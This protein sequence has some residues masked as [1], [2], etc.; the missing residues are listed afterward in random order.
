MATK[1]KPQSKAKAAAIK[2]RNKGAEGPKKPNFVRRAEI[3]PL[4]RGRRG[5]VTPKTTTSL[6]MA[7][8]QKTIADVLTGL[9]FQDN[10][11]NAN[12]QW[13]RAANRTL[14][15]AKAQEGAK[16]AGNSARSQMAV[17]RSR[18]VRRATPKKK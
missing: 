5:G 8:V 16:K 14:G 2:A 3:R 13:R 9:P 11:S 15:Q 12:V 10:N 6:T 18:R 1:P 17:T 7:Q 4:S